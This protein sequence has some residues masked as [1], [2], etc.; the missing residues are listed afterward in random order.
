MQAST[1]FILL[2][3]LY[4]EQRERWSSD[5]LGKLPIYLNSSLNS[6]TFKK[7]IN[8]EQILFF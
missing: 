8:V 3:K 1:Y 7:T 4:S 2:Y 5:K 6:T